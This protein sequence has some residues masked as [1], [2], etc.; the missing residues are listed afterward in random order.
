VV[1]VNQQRID[2]WNSDQLPIFEP[3]L[4]EI[5]KKQRGKNLFFSA[6][7]DQ[8]IRDSEVVFISVN[9]PTKHYGL[10]AGKAAAGMAVALENELGPELLQQKKVFGWVNV[11]ADCLLPTSH[12]HLHA[13]RPAGVNEPR[14]QGVEGTREIIK[15]VGSLQENDLCICLLAGGGS[16][17]LVAPV[18]EI[19][20]EQL[21]A[22]TKLL[23]ACGANIQQLNTVRRQISQVKGGGLAQPSGCPR[24]VCEGQRPKRQARV[25]LA[26]SGD[27]SDRADSE[28]RSIR[29]GGIS[30]EVQ[31]VYRG[32]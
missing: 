26:G 27:G 31:R 14:Q 5:V 4:D 22:I 20:L 32:K 12:I 25:G 30:R 3:G 28:E 13:G 21:I 7:I 10:G 11:P 6:E 29:S 24:S 18:E 15:L 23:S 17:L 2:A 1:D 16:A 19:S 8:T 9:T